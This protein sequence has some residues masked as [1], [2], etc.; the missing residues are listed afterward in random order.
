MGW[1]RA[2]VGVPLLGGG[3]TY[4]RSMRLR[5]LFS[6]DGAD[7]AMQPDA[8]VAPASSAEGGRAGRRPSPVT[9]G[10]STFPTR[11]CHEIQ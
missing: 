10:S 8:V 5:T 7:A 3:I 9:S 1:G 4:V 2:A 11:Q 6:V